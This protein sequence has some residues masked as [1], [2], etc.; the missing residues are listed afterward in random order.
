MVAPFLNSLDNPFIW[1]DR[2]SIVDNRSI[3]SLWPLWGP[4][5]PPAETPVASRPLVNLSFALNYSL[6]G[7]DVR[8]YHLVNLGL[9]LLTAW[10]L[11]AIVYRTLTRSVSNA[12]SH[13]HASVTALL[14]TVVWAVHPMVSEVVN[15]T[16][17][18]SDA[19]GG[20]FLLA[21]LFA[22]QRALSSPHRG[23]WHVVAVVAC[24]CGVLA[25]EFVAVT[26][27]IV[28]LYDRVFAFHSF[29][30]AFAVRKN[31]YVALVATWIPL[32]VILALRPHSTIGFAAGVDAW[33]YL[34]N[35]AEMLVR[36]L[37][38][39]VWPDALVID[40]GVP[41]P[42]SLGTVWV[43][44]LLIAALCA[45]SIV[46]LFRW[47]RVGFLC[48]VFFLLL[49][50]SSSIIPIVTEV[51]AERRMYLSLAALTIFVVAGSAWA[52]D[53]VRP[54]MPRRVGQI[55]PAAAVAVTVA[56]AG[57][58]GV[59][60]THRNSEYA[61][62]VTLW[63]SSI[64]RWPQ[65]R[66]RIAYAVALADGGDRD[67][68][69]SQLRLAVRDYPQARSALGRELAGSGLYA[70]AARELSTF[71]ANEPREEA[72][73]PARILLAGI[74]LEHGDPAD[75]AEQYRELLR[76]DPDDAGWLVGRARALALSR[77]F[78]EA[79]AAYR[80]AL[81]VAPRAVEA[82]AGLA[83]VLLEMGQ[84]VDAA[85]Q[86][87][88]ALQLEPGDAPS[89]NILGAALA[90]QGRLDEAIAHFKQAIAIDFRYTEA[91]NNLARAERQLAEPSNPPR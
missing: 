50:P 90:M 65:G 14:A 21:T 78:D 12:R 54:H 24:V 47:P 36:Y 91:R 2:A 52:I 27:L 81:R 44:G 55:L 18:R 15:Y 19:L 40:Y 6:H 5:V 3:R 60:T 23:R 70:E 88:A 39:A 32:A 62:A 64:E 86:A 46:A 34:L 38:L 16:T 66:A 49:A 4:I 30:E 9:H 45:A 22:A 25:K 1:D 74:L 82:H 37:R 69:I 41:R 43:S 76:H 58:L 13:G 77:R 67:S 17:Q 73:R 53:R 28:L 80:E 42:L 26:P 31:L 8:G 89:H 84:A 7:L 72:Q 75:A 11:F 10:L 48:A 63:R 35:Q 56:V 57:T 20:L 79:A 29:R 51:G 87:R 85:E 61:T 33:T 83:A 71:I 59:L 68:A